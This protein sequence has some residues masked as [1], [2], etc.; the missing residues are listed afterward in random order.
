MR[1]KLFLLALL[2]LSTSHIQA[3][4]LNTGALDSLFNYIAANHQG[5]GHITIS[6]HGNVVYDRCFGQS[7]V[8]V[9]KDQY[10]IGSITKT[11]TATLIHKQCQKG[12][13]SLDTTLDTY[14][15]Q[16][17]N[18]DKITIGHMLQHTSG[19]TDYTIKP[20]NPMWLTSE[21][22]HEE[23]MNEILR[24]GVI[25]EPGTNTRYSN[26]AYYLLGLIVEQLYGAPLKSVVHDELLTPLNLH[27]TFAGITDDKDAATPYRINTAG[28]WQ[29]VDDFYFGN[30]PGVGDM[31]STPGNLIS[32]IESL[33]AGNILPAESLTLM[34]PGAGEM[35][36]KGLMLV[37]F[38]DHIFYGHAGDTY[39]SNTLV[40]H[41]P[42]DSTSIAICLN[43]CSMSRNDILINV[44]SIIYDY[45]YEYP[46]FA[47]PYA[48]TAAELKAYAGTFNTD[49]INLPM[50][51]EYNAE[52]GNLS[53]RLDGQPASWLQAK[54]PG[55]FVNTLL[56]VG[57]SFK[58]N[59]RFIFK[60]NNQIIIYNRCKAE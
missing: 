27:N 38:Y 18:A 10:R 3:T 48:V 57:I 47:A 15:P 30:V 17:A 46:T 31:I 40:M 36:G 13:I 9:T 24:Q 33:F 32:Y 21:K 39:G 58:N 5:I 4:S 34:L 2:L 16:I 12:A 6:Q 29:E 50:Y 56:N 60:Q 7:D 25:F 43:G 19:L 37:P 51:L 52:D 28:T 35:F 11:F 23:I 1:N 54:A 8:P 14:F 41:N 44:C 55:V 45:D 49:I 53:L 42:T 26:T 59:D 22:T 20:D